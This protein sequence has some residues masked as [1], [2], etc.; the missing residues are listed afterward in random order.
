M[1]PQRIPNRGWKR[2]EFTTLVPGGARVYETETL[3]AIVSRDTDKRY[4]HISISR[5]D[6]CYPNWDEIADA[7]YDLIPWDVDMALLL[8]PP[9]DYVNHHLTVLQLTE[10]RD[11]DMPIDRGAAMPRSRETL[12]GMVGAESVVC[13]L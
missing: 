6:G 13:R 3:R 1:S 10:V 7:R 9:D 2:R 5:S 8:P 4:W 11:P 12:A